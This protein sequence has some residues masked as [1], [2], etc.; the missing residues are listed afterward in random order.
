M[1]ITSTIL[2]SEILNLKST[3]EWCVC[4]CVCMC[5]SVYV[6]EVYG[7]KYVQR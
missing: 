5:V 1:V 4:V 3:C 2:L 7:S 6:C